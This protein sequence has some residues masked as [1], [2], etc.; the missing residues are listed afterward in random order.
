VSELK[1]KPLLLTKNLSEQVYELLRRDILKGVFMPEEKLQIEAVSEKYDIG[2]VPLREA[3][4]RLSAEGLVERIKQRGF[5]V[6]PLAVDDLEQ[7]VSTRIWAET[8]A[9]SDSIHHSDDGWE[10]ELVLSFHRLARVSRNMTSAPD[11]EHADE[12]DFRHKEFHMQLI[13]KCG[14]RWLLDFCSKMMDQAV[15]YRHVSM[16]ISSTLA[17]REGA[18]DEHKNILDAVLDQDVDGA[19][20]LLK[21]HYIKTLKALKPDHET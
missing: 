12:W 15:R 5:F 8:K 3:L 13:S 9:L 1:E 20:E 11:D 17:R 16:N 6:A 18:A 21:H 4:N 10:D 14:S 7:L 19:C 2:A